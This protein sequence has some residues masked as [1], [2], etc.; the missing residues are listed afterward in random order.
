MDGELITNTYQVEDVTDQTTFELDCQLQ[1][2]A[3]ACIKVDWGYITWL[4]S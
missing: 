2:F 3:W 4:S 1:R